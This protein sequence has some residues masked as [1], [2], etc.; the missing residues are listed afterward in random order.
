MLFTL[1]SVEVIEMRVVTFTIS[2]LSDMGESAESS[3]SGVTNGIGAILAI[4]VI[5]SVA[6][7]S[8]LGVPIGL[9]WGVVRATSAARASLKSS[10]SSDT[11][12]LDRDWEARA[13]KSPFGRGVPIACA[14]YK[15]GALS[16][17]EA[18]GWVGWFVHL[19]R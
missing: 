9:R 5:F 4:L 17:A 3:C 19:H 8:N 16:E 12:N 15:E 6:S 18:S 2:S 14:V 1:R 7:T 13:E 10:S 11:A